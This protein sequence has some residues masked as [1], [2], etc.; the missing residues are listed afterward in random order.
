[1]PP[2]PGLAGLAPVTLGPGELDELCALHAEL[3]RLA[4]PR[5]PFVRESDG[6]FARHLGRDGVVLGLRSATGALAAYAVLGLPGPDDALNF[7]ADLGL[8]PAERARVFHLDGTGVRPAWRGRGLQR[9]LVTE[10]LRLGV[11]AGRAVALSAVSPRNPRSLANLIAAGLRVVALVEKYGDVRFMLH[12][13]AEVLPAWSTAA[14]PHRRVPL[15]VAPA[16]HRA[17]LAA[18]W[19]GVTLEPGPGGAALVYDAGRGAA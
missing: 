6:F 2:A 3:H 15:D 14:G 8:A 11:A 12:W 7:G 5:A 13:Q 19:H 16:E 18:G 17:L 4:G 10:R 1:M 9:W